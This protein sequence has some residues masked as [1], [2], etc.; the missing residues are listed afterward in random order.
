MLDNLKK[1]YSPNFDSKKRKSRNI[2]FIILHYTGMKKEKN[3]I[4]RL[5]DANSKVSCHY[6]I[7][8]SGKII[9]L[10]PD[11]YISWHA[12]KSNW[13]KIKSL[14]S[15]SLGVEISNP[16]HE[17]GYCNY[18]KKQIK[19]IIFLISTLKK[20]YKIKNQNILGHSDIAPDRKKDPGE[21]FPWKFM[22]DK[23]L[24]IWHNLDE[25]KLTRLRSQECNNFEIRK[26]FNNLKIIGYKSKN[27]INI[28]KAFQRRFRQKLISGKI[29]KEC[30][31]ISTSLLKN[32]KH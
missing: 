3:A 1:I 25:K 17:N 28:I 10:V 27:K 12:G 16:G 21:K 32:N 26:F 23:K 20:I 8:N 19:S 6:L 7:T 24:S 5:T 31:F 11:L 22:Y 30:L 15:S 4:N 13:K 14:N 2:K 18:K 9:N 29:D